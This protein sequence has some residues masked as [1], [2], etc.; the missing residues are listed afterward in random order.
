MLLPVTDTQNLR[1]AV[2]HATHYIIQ[3][4]LVP[5]PEST[6][7]ASPHRKICPNQCFPSRTGK[8][9]LASEA[10]SYTGRVPDTPL[11]RNRHR[12]LIIGSVRI[13]QRVQ[14]NGGGG[15]FGE[16]AVVLRH[17]QGDHCKQ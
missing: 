6:V 11:Y 1:Q 3:P 2:H 10:S 13:L 14:D 7:R 16:A 8:I 17:S 12:V 5:S 15:R 4:S 9:R